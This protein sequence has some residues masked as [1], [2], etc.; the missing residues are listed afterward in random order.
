MTGI[1]LNLT[2]AQMAPYFLDFQLEVPY[3]NVITKGPRELKTTLM[4]EWTKIY[5]IQHS[6]K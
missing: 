4:L 5:P 3:T 6:L 1:F 2:H